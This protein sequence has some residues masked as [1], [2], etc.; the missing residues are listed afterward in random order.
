MK[1]IVR[2][3]FKKTTA[4]CVKYIKFIA[5][6]T[7]FV[8]GAS[9]IVPMP[10]IATTEVDTPQYEET[11]NVTGEEVEPGEGP[12]QA[13]DVPEYISNLMPGN[14]LANKMT[15][16][17]V[18]NMQ[19][20]M[21]VINTCVEST[22]KGVVDALIIDFAPNLR[23]FFAA[24]G[25][26][27]DTFIAN[28]FTHEYS[29]SPT[30]INLASVF[31]IIAFSF[32]TLIFAAN[33][34]LNV[35]VHSGEPTETPL[36]SLLKF[37]LTI[38]LIAFSHQILGPLLDMA[39]KFYNIFM[40]IGGDG[41]LKINAW[42]IV[43]TFSTALGNN[44][45]GVFAALGA[46]ADA[47]EEIFRCLINI[48]CA[49]F[50]MKELLK[51]L[52]EFIERYVI[53]G[54]LFITS[55]IAFSFC[56]TSR[57]IKIFSAY[58][59]MFMSE[60]FLLIVNVFFVK[61]FCLLTTGL[62]DWEGNYKS[63]F[64]SGN[65]SIGLLNFL[66][67]IAYLKVAQNFD[68]YLK[69]LGL[70]TAQSAGNI[71]DQMAIGAHLFIAN[72]RSAGKMATGAAK[73][74]I[75][76][77]AIGGSVAAMQMYNAL[78]K[79]VTHGGKGE[80]YASMAKRGITPKGEP[81]EKAYQSVSAGVKNG[82]YQAMFNRNPETSTAKMFGGQSNMAKTLGLQEGSLKNLRTDTAKGEITGIGRTADGHETAF[83]LKNGTVGNNGTATDMY[84]GSWGVDFKD[85][86][87]S[88]RPKTYNDFS[89]GA[90]NGFTKHTGITPEQFKAATNGIDMA[91]VKS[92]ENVSPGVYRVD[93]NDTN[94]AGYFV[95]NAKD[96]FEYQADEYRDQWDNMSLYTQLKT[97]YPDID[98][99]SIRY[100]EK[101]NFIQFD[102]NEGHIGVIPS[103][104]TR[105]VMKTERVA[106]TKAPSKGYVNGGGVY[107]SFRIKG[108]AK[109]RA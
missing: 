12:L 87:Q 90:D 83:T 84:G 86:P 5:I 67:I 56:V 20:F 71:I 49:F 41:T 35:F 85:H 79:G 103:E 61:G 39:N 60:L 26:T 82:S 17:M 51:V 106:G 75:G 81:S 45:H 30:I 31:G 34:I 16:I 18:S 100:N 69:N 93:T 25:W 76:A 54:I 63:V 73:L 94:S 52:A 58:I 21:N 4:K 13:E 23:V 101:N 50:L 57:T 43:H 9:I 72:A 64:S 96:G 14:W 29:S 88:L 80:A 92:I 105:Y 15:N 8:L 59:R 97:M 28:L 78:D 99:D 1:D 62:Y 37:A 66:F 3:Y 48:F 53:T 27:G 107:G 36:Q 95:G 70:N 74:P 22:V 6:A 65:A 32:A 19:A 44:S 89:G 55:P 47:V 2:D 98:K 11:W 46:I 7:A 42:G 109:A 38:F 77:A 91:D 104:S 108:E 102:V 68:A 24:F 10:T 33:L 40:S